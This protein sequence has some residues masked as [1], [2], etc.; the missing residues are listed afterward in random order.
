MKNILF[1]QLKLPGQ[2][3]AVSDPILGKSITLTE[4]INFGLSLLFAVGIL[5]SLLFLIL[6]GISWITSGGDKEKLEKSRKTIIFAMIGLIILL[7]SVII[8]NLIGTFLGAR[9]F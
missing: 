5:A 1:I 4:I 2:D 3:K 8:M 6:G 7:L 9:I